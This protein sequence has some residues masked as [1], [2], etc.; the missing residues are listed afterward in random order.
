MDDTNIYFRNFSI[1]RFYWCCF[2]DDK[3]N[4]FKLNNEDDTT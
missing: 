4:V 3:E 2:M 1:T